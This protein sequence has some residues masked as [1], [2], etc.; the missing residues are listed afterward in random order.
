MF[1]RKLLWFPNPSRTFFSWNK[2]NECV[3]EPIAPKKESK[4]CLKKPPPPPP[5]DIQFLRP[6]RLE[7]PKVRHGIFPEEWF[8][9]FYNKTG[10]SGPYML[11]TGILTYLFSKEIYVCEHEFYSGLSMMITC[12]FFVKKVGP[13]IAKYCDKELDKVEDGWKNEKAVLTKNLDNEIELERKSQ[14]AAEGGILMINAKKENVQLQLEADYRRRFIE[15][16][17]VVK[18]RLDYLVACRNIEQRI[19]HKHKVNW[20][21]IQTISSI[22]AEHKKEEIDKC[23]ADLSALATTMKDIK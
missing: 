19:A 23:F 8:T 21:I 15:A 22:T 1:S 5:I 13:T 11:G 17:S 16:H 18:N 12:I 4:L 3:C 14:Y 20:V 9:M 7:P 6:V 2:K 10:V